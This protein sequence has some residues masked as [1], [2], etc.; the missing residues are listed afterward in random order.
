MIIGQSYV[1]RQT[2]RHT[3][4]CYDKTQLFQMIGEWLL[5]L[6]V[7]ELLVFLVNTA[8]QC[9]I[10]SGFFPLEQHYSVHVCFLIILLSILQ[11]INNTLLTCVINKTIQSN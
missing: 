3:I 5:T 9:G 6:K 10:I 1:P 8:V 2:G 4:Q 11:T 7:S